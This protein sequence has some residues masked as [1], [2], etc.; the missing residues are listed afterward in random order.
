MEKKTIID[1]GT[2]RIELDRNLDVDNKW[3]KDFVETSYLG[4]SIQ[5]DWNPAVRRS[6]SS[7]TCT[8]TLI[9]EDVIKDMRRLAVFTGVCHVRTP[10]G[11]SYAADVQVSESWSHDRGFLIAEYTLDI[12]RVD[13]DRYDGIRLDE[14]EA[15]ND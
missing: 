6:G 2:G 1:F 3:E 14:W 8:I 5:G 9:D 13:G 10:D 15:G 4:G 12:T 7:S 11:S